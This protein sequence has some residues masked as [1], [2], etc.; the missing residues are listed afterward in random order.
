MKKRHLHADQNAAHTGA[1]AFKSLC[2]SEATLAD[3]RV[4]S[5]HHN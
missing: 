5:H 4:L 1:H 2:A 3:M